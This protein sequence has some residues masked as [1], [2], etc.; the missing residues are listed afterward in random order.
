MEKMK[1]LEKKN[2]TQNT[3]HEDSYN[4]ASHMEMRNELMYHRMG[5]K[6]TSLMHKYT[7]V[8]GICST[9]YLSVEQ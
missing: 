1:A 4:F 8:A 9:K 6:F 7:Q 5:G 2:F 3:S